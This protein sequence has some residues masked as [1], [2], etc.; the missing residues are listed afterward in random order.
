MIPGQVAV[1]DRRQQL[2]LH[3]GRELVLDVRMPE[4]EIVAAAHQL[5]AE[6]VAV[7]LGGAGD[8]AHRDRDVVESAHLDQSLPLPVPTAPV[9]ARIAG[10]EKFCQ[11]FDRFKHRASVRHKRPAR[12][13]GFELRAARRRGKS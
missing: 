5:P 2:D 9:P 7:E 13:L 11:T 8:V 1:A 10:Y 3:P 12:P 4:L 6:D